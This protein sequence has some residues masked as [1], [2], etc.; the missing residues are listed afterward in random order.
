MS[1]SSEFQHQKRFVGNRF[2]GEIVDH[3]DHHHAED[4]DDH[5]FFAFCCVAPRGGVTGLPAFSPP[6]GNF[7]LSAGFRIWKEHISVSSTDIIAPAD[8]SMIVFT[9][10]G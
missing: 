8:R 7:F 2:L 10:A 1:R 6:Y 4:D 3:K 5:F 9:R